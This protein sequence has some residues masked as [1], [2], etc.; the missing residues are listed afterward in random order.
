M[1]LEKALEANTD[2]VR[3]LIGM[4]R[5][6]VRLATNI[7]EGFT[8]TPQKISETKA[9][10]TKQAQ[11]NPAAEKAG[12]E[13]PLAQS[14]QAAAFGPATAPA[15]SPVAPKP[16]ASAPSPT[17]ESVADAAPASTV[18]TKLVYEKDVG[19]RITALAKSDRR[20]DVVAALSAFGVKRGT[21]LTEEQWAP[22]LEM[23]A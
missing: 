1:S 7:P 15:E 23:L 9:E 3:E 13:A 5:E 4:I 16:T 20:G 21:E 14:V 22:F 11:Q 17:A 18:A 8:S 10:K 6:A 19:P 12:G 2:A